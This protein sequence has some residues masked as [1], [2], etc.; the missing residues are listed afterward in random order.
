[1]QHR[2]VKL[3]LGET[4]KLLAVAWPEKSLLVAVAGVEEVEA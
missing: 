2:L 1:L 4:I 3:N